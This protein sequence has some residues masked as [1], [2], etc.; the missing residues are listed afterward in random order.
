MRQPFAGLFLVLLAPFSPEQPP[1]APPRT[2]PAQLSPRSSVQ[3]PPT[4]PT[5]L[6]P[7]SLALSAVA[8]TLSP[9]WARLQPPSALVI[10]LPSSFHSQRGGACRTQILSLY[11][12]PDLLVAPGL[13]VKTGHPG[14]SCVIYPN[15]LPA[16]PHSLTPAPRRPDTRPHAPSPLMMGL[17]PTLASTARAFSPPDQDLQRRAALP[18]RLASQQTLPELTAPGHS[19]APHPMR[20][21]WT[22]CIH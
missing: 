8:P 18:L 7:S 22:R 5:F 14:A 13:L 12:V 9:T 16:L 15:T 10:T 20:V 19:T 21:S 2:S 6:L 17:S 4:N 11:L 3:R 1:L